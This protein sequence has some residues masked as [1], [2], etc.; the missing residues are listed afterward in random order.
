MTEFDYVAVAQH[1]HTAP[2]ATIPRMPHLD[3]EARQR[4]TA[5]LLEQVV[6]AEPMPAMDAAPST[7]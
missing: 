2:L 3:A 6:P 5:E 1:I 4:L 7:D